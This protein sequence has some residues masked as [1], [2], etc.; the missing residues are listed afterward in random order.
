[1]ASCVKRP[2]V[3]SGDREV[4]KM[5]VI[6]TVVI[7]KKSKPRVVDV[8]LLD[9]I[10]RGAD[11]LQRDL[12]FSSTYVCGEKPSENRGGGGDREGEI[13]DVVLPFKCRKSLR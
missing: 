4:D 7:Q 8:R 3:T 9:Q 1:M 2:V 5:D 12:Q 6:Q 11:F 10:L 13:A